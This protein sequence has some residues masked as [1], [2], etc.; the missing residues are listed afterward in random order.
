MKLDLRAFLSQGW[1]L[2]VYLNQYN[3]D[4]IIATAKKTWPNKQVLYLTK[5]RSISECD[6]QDYMGP[7]DV[8]AILDVV[9][10]ALATTPPE[11]TSV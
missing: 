2:R 3:P 7:A 8:A 10:A 1:E 5:S 6:A 11:G 9:Y 4:E